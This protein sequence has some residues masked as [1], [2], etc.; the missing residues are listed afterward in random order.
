[1]HACIYTYMTGKA[2]LTCLQQAHGASNDEQV[3][4]IV[5]N[6]QFIKTH[7]TLVRPRWWNCKSPS[8]FCTHSLFDTCKHTRALSERE[9]KRES[10]RDALSERETERE[11]EMGEILTFRSNHTSMC[12]WERVHVRFEDSDLIILAYPAQMHYH[13]N[14]HTLC[15]REGPRERALWHPKKCIL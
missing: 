8:P 13:T 7:A 3:G 5:N 4:H 12:V 15:R 9:R 6:R 11:R 10:E 1:M 2:P 14:T